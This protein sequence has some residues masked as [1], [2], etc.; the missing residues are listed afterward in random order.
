MPR[1]LN[2]SSLGPRLS[3]PE[4]LTRPDVAVAGVS[5]VAHQF[6]HEHAAIH[7]DDGTFLVWLM[8]F[9]CGLKNIDAVMLL[10]CQ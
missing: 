10:T 3:W 2:D 9:N 5:L 8:L 6:I 4:A 7:I 1:W